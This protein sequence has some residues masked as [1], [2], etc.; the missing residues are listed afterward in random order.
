V[1]GPAPE[2]APIE[3]QLGGVAVDFQSTEV[4]NAVRAACKRLWGRGPRSVQVLFAGE[5]T[6]VVMLSGIFTSAERTLL[7]AAREVTVI[8][9]RAGLHEALEPEI[10]VLLEATFGRETDAFISG[11]DVD[12]DVA[13]LVVTM[14][15]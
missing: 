15:R 9:Q 13:S 2:H 6:V 1:L 7:A 5:D 11:I 8:A 10:R 12:R 14:A 3:R 4:A